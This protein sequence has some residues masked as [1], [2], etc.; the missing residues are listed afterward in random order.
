[1]FPWESQGCYHCTKSGVNTL[2]V[3]NRTSLYGINT[4]LH[5]NGASLNGIN[6]LLLLSQWESN[7]QTSERNIQIIKIT[8]VWRSH[9]FNFNKIVFETTQN[10][11]TSTTNLHSWLDTNVTKIHC[12]TCELHVHTKIG[13]KWKYFQI[14]GKLNLNP[15]LSRKLI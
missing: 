12:G 2:L 10:F 1:M 15:I 11:W 5:L 6:T 8:K 13:K 4:L 3:L 7:N 9:Y 14:Q